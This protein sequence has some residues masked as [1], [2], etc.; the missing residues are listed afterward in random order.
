MVLKGAPTGAHL[1]LSPTRTKRAG[2]LAL[3]SEHFNSKRTSPRKSAPAKGKGGSAGP[4]ANCPSTPASTMPCYRRTTI[5]SE[6]PAAVAEAEAAGGAEYT[7]TEIGMQFIPSKRH[8]PWGAEQ[9]SK[10]RARGD[11]LAD[12]AIDEVFEIRRRGGLATSIG[13]DDGDGLAAVRRGAALPLDGVGCAKMCEELDRVP[14]WADR[15]AVARAQRFFLLHLPPATQSLLFVGLIGGFG[16]PLI[17]PTLRAT[18]YLTSTDA[19]RT[20]R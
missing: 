14:E 19:G 5:F 9:W 1:K 7:Q 18:G 3:G 2:S 15:A 11:P 10:L 12:A 17:T 6:P 16:A 20:H 8:L 4:D 13:G